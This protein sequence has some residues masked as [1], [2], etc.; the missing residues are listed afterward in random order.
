MVQ[1][2]ECGLSSDLEFAASF[3]KEWNLTISANTFLDEFSTWPRAFFPGAKELVRVLKQQ[4][5]VGCLSNSNPLHWEKF[6]DELTVMFDIILSSHVLG[7]VKP[8]PDIFLKTLE[9][10]SV[11]ADEIYFFDDCL[12]NVQTA[13]SLNI[14]AFCVSGFASLVHTL[15]VQGLLHSSALPNFPQTVFCNA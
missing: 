12:A 9:K 11:Q 7:S 3:V 6:S 1:I 13:Q 5:R 4:H 2:F 15:Q 8:N 14:N 10:C